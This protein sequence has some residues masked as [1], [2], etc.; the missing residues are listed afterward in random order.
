[1]ILDFLKSRGTLLALIFIAL[2]GAA[3]KF[4]NHQLTGQLAQCQQSKALIVAAVKEAD[5]LAEAA[6][7][8]EERRS[9]AHATRSEA[10]HD[11][12][13]ERATAAAGSYSATHRVTSDRVRGQAN[14]GEGGETSATSGSDGSGVP[15]E[16]SADHDVVVSSLDLQACTAAVTYAVAAHNWAQTLPGQISVGTEREQQDPMAAR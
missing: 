4:E 9:A 3:L 14:G 12:D 13:L 11:Q 7:E 8:D 5:A 16:V 6:R 15:A 2:W 10:S 1:V